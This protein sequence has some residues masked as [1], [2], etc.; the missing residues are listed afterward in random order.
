M[1]QLITC[2]WIAICA[3]IGT[4]AVAQTW[5]PLGNP[6][7]FVQSQTYSLDLM[8]PGF[9]NFEGADIFIQ[10][11]NLVYD[12][13]VLL[14]GA[15]SAIL[16]IPA[17]AAPLNLGGNRDE[18]K[19]SIFPKNPIT[20]DGIT[21][22]AGALLGVQ[23]KVKDNAP[24]GPTTANVNFSFQLVDPTD[25]TAEPTPISGFVN[26]NANILAVPEP[27]AW[28]TMFTGLGLV[29]IA[30]ARSRRRADRLRL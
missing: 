2:I 20:L 26:V 22:P 7:Q 8:Q 12:S 19:I 6:Y 18:I 9:S 1:R 15:F 5:A 21:V 13:I 27:S 28:M 25:I 23:F 24:L 29:G 30:L 3:A 16:D 11:S 17:P 14:P 4:P 10:Y